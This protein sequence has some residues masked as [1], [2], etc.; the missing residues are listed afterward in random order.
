MSQLISWG[1]T[2]CLRKIGLLYRRYGDRLSY[3]V[4]V[5]DEVTIFTGRE[6]EGFARQLA[7][8]LGGVVEAPN[9]EIQPQKTE[10]FLVADVIKRFVRT[11]KEPGNMVVF[12]PIS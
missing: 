9:T 7:D 5:E 2:N 10:E 8:I 1:I 12:K 6:P 3:S 4:F 11:I